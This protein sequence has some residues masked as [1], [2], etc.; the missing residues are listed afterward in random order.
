MNIDEARS[1]VGFHGVK[2][3]VPINIACGLDIPTGSQ[4][5]TPPNSALEANR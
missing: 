3:S 4:S 5:G 2:R 1:L